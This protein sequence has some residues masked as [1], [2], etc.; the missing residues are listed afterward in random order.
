M[1]KILRAVALAALIAGPSLAQQSPP[2]LDW[3]QIQTERFK[4]VFPA[5]ISADAQ[6]VANT[7][8]HIYGPVSKTLRGPHKPIDIVLVNQL[9]QPNGF[10]ALAPRR[11][12]WFSTPPQNAGLLSGDWYQVLAIH[13]MRHVVQFDRMRRGFVRLAWILTGEQGEAIASA[14]LVPS[15]FWEGDAVGVETALSETGRGR[16]PQFGLHIRSLLLTGRRYSYYKAHHRSYRDWYPSH[17][18]L[19]YFLTTYVKRRYGPEMWDKVLG[20]TARWGFHPFSFSRALRK[21]IGASAAQTYERTMDELTE[22][23][24]AQQKDLP[25]TPLRVLAGQSRS[26]VWT[27]YEYPHLL[28]DGSVLA[29]K[30]G[31]ADPATLVRL[32]PDGREERLRLYQSL[33]S[34]RAAGGKVAWNRSTPDP[35]WGLRGYSDVVVL[36]LDSGQTRQLTHK[37]KLFAPAPSPDGTRIAAIEF[38]PDRTCHLVLLET[39][40]GA[41]QARFSAPDGVFWRTPAWSEDGRYIAVVRQDQRGKALERLDTVNGQGQIALPHTHADI[42]WPVCWG[43]YLLFDA[44]YSGIDNIHAVHLPSGARYQVTSRPLAATRA[45]VAGDSLLFQEYTVDGYRIAVMPLDPATWTPVEQVADRQVRYYEPLIAQ[46][47]GGSILADIPQRSYPVSTYRPL[48]HLFEVHSWSYSPL[49]PRYALS[50]TSSDLLHL[51]STSGGVEYNHNESAFSALGDFSLAAWYPIFSVGGRW[52]ERAGDYEIKTRAIEGDSPKVQE[53]T[54]RWTEKSLSAG[55]ELPLDLSR[56]PWQSFFHLSAKAEWTDIADR[57]ALNR[58]EDDLYWPDSN[59]V[60]QA[61]KDTLTNNHNGRFAPLTYQLSFGRARHSAWRD[62][63]PVWGQSLQ[64]IYRHTP[65]A[66][67]YDGTLLSGRLGLLFPGLAAHHSL[68][69]EGAY[70]WQ[71]PAGANTDALPYRFASE[72]PFVRGYDYEFHHRFYLGTANYALPLLYPDWNLG[73]LVYLQRVKVNLFYDYSRGE[74]DA[75]PPKIYQTAGAELTT[76]FHPFSLPIP[77]DMGLRYAYRFEEKDSRYE[78]VVNLQ[79]F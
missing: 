59:S 26:S 63:A 24:Q 12:V 54:D 16:M 21:Y 47:Q 65:F 28:A 79:R 40:S 34:I 6:R 18:P 76:N 23:W 70:E 39:A 35:R 77:L 41:E 62:L 49:P 9:A 20:R 69:L 43:S 60:R 1:T 11:S 13:E 38:G 42:G 66:G 29:S 73:A 14:L 50:L 22:L 33:G 78:V 27:N 58:P 3:R 72:Q 4:V 67:D 2:G 44:P 55:V 36:D 7:L 56:G 5:A 30:S 75:Q 74:D 48:G 71:D 53:E 64:L 45:A 25:T 15:W 31:L 61:V 51:S 37:A 68:Q 32:H 8:E 19:G 10:V 17:Y 52:G 46:E 57:D